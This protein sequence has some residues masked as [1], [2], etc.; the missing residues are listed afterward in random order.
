MWTMISVDCLAYLVD[1]VVD[2]SEIPDRSSLTYIVDDVISFLTELKKQ[3]G[4]A[5]ALAS[6]TEW[7][8]GCF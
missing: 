4:Y 3:C 1:N 7:F 8:L 2:V 5:S 6:A